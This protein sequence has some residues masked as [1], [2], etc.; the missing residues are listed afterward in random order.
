MSSRGFAANRSSYLIAAICLALMA[1]ML[2][3][4]AMSLLTSVKPA[5]EAGMWPPKYLPSRLSFSNY[6]E[7]YNYQAGLPLYLFNSFSVAFM[8][9][10]GLSVT[11]KIYVSSLMRGAIR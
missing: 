7:M 9:I 5:G 4:L 2:F 3:P 10:T 6:L 8:T 1:V 11:A